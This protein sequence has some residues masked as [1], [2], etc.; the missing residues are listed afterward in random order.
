M[1]FYNLVLINQHTHDEYWLQADLES[2]QETNVHL[3][4][5]KVGEAFKE[6]LSLDILV[7]HTLPYIQVN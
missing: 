1:I 2:T 7:T 3:A 4:V 6:T 5:T